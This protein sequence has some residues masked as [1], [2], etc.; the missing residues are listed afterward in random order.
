MKIFAILLFL[1]FAPLAAALGGDDAT[2]T[3]PEKIAENFKNRKTLSGKFSQ[4]KRLLDLDVALQSSG[5][6]VFSAKKGMLWQTLAPAKSTILLNPDA[7]FFFDSNGA[8][9][10]KIEIGGNNTAAEISQIVREI[11]LGEFSKLEKTFAETATCNGD[12]W[13]LTL[14][15]KDKSGAFPFEKITISGNARFAEKIVFDSEKNSESTEICF[16]DVATDDE[17]SESAFE[18]FEK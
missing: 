13:T 6:F 16:S 3:T 14:A 2:A 7:I 5:N 9:S 17:K 4:T 18:Q 8:L 11:M 10:Q 1:I 12:K 15:A